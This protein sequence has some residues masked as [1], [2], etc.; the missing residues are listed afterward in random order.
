MPQSSTV[1][2]RTHPTALAHACRRD[3]A[4]LLGADE[5]VAQA[6]GD[7]GRVLLGD[8]PLCLQPLH[9]DPAGPWIAFTQ[10]VRPPEVAEDTWC[11]ALLRATLHGLTVT[12][13]A[14]GVTD[15]GDAVLTL[16]TPAGCDHP[17]VLAA[18]MAGLLSLRQALLEGVQAAAKA[19]PATDAA[20]TRPTPGPSAEAPAPDAQEFEA[21]DEVL[22]LVHGALLHVGLSEAQAR[23]ALRTGALQLEGID[24]GLACDGD[25]PTLVVAADLGTD[26]L[27][28]PDERRQALLANPG[29]MATAGVAMARE[30]GRTRLMARCHLE[31]HRPEVFADWLGHFA[32]LAQSTLAHRRATTLH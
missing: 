13:V 12:H 23:T 19:A 18:E 15:G 21:P 2:S 22:A 32:R 10:A 8:T 11:N 1:P 28:T 25:T 4:R 30:H 9:D 29:L 16:R 5:A 20:N 24:L 27:A 3:A 6:F 31:G 14:Y 17:D 26:T 7:S